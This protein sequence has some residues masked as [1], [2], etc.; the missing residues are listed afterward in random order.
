MVKHQERRRQNNV[1]QAFLEVYYGLILGWTFSVGEFPNIA[2]IF[3]A[4]FLKKQ[5][6]PRARLWENL[7]WAE[8][9]W[10]LE[11]LGQPNFLLRENS[12]IIPAE[13]IDSRLSAPQEDE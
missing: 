13:T 8:S 10:N 1:R 5:F 4:C 7:I 11:N 2:W 3:F 9:P 6:V 12:L